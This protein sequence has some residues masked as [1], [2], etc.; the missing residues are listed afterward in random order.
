MVLEKG[1]I[2]PNATFQEVNPRIDVDFHNLKV[3]EIQTMQIRFKTWPANIEMLQFPTECTFWPCK[4]LRRASVASFGFG[5]SNSHVV[6]DDAY[7]YMAYRGIN[8]THY[9]T[10]NQS[11]AANGFKV[12]QSSNGLSYST[13][14]GCMLINGDHQSVHDLRNNGLSVAEDHEAQAESSKLLVLSAADE[15]GVARLAQK[16]ED[17]FRNHQDILKKEP[18][19]LRHLAY[20]LFARKSTFPWKSFVVVNSIE[21]LGSFSASVSKPLNVDTNAQ[22]VFVFTGQGAQ[23]DNMGAELFAYPVFRRIIERFDE[24]LG[25]L[26]CSWSVSCLLQQSDQALDIND[27]EYSQAAATALQ[28]GAYEIL[29]ELGV[30]VAL[31][32]GHSSGEIAAAYA[33]GA[34]SLE[35][36]CRVSYWRGKHASELKLSMASKPG[37]MMSVDLS[38]SQAQAILASFS[39][40]YPQED[41]PSIACINSPLNVT[42]SGEEAAIDLVQD[43]LASQKV[44]FRK[45][46]TGV[47]YHSPHMQAMA[48]AYAEKLNVLEPASRCTKDALQEHKRPIMISSV[49]GQRVHDITTLCTNDYWVQ[50]LVSQVRFSTAM[51]VVSAAIGRKRRRKLGEPKLNVQDIIE[52]G[53]HSALR[54]PV[55]ACLETSGVKNSRD[56]YHSI[57]SRG[58]PAAQSLL[59]LVGRLYSRGYPVR[60]CEANEMRKTH[61]NT[62]LRLI[63]DL[64]SYPFNHTKS[65]WSESTISKNTR[66]RNGAALHEL[67]GIPVPDW[68]AREPRWRKFFDLNETPWI[69]HH[70]VNGRI[71]YPAAGMIAMAIEGAK[72][73]TTED[74]DRQIVAYQIRDA[75]FVA[76]I[77][78]NKSERTE[79]QLHMRLNSAQSDQSLT[80]FEF[81]I[82]SIG[83]N[84]WFQNCNGIVQV[85][86][87]KVDSLN[88]GQA[89][90]AALQRESNFY[91]QKYKECAKRSIHSVP[92]RKMY[93]KLWSNGLQFGPA[94]Q[95]LN[96]MAWDGENTAVGV[97]KCFQ[98]E[99]GSELSYNGRQEHVV[100]PTSLDGAGHLPWVALTKGGEEKIVSGT[101]VT[102]IQYAWI[103]GNGLSYPSTSQIRAC[104]ETS[105]KG[106]RGTDSSIFAL[107]DAGNLVLRISNLETTALGGDEQ[108]SLV[109]HPQR[110]CYEMSYQPELDCLD[111]KQLR[112]FIDAGTERV[113]DKHISFYEDLELVLFYFATTALRDGWSTEGTKGR[114]H[115][116]KYVS[117]LN[118][119][120]QRY[121][122]CELPHGRPEWALRSQ[123]SAAMEDLINRLANTNAEGRF[124]ASVGRKL[125]SILDGTTDPLELMFQTDLAEK[126]YQSICDHMMW[127]K[128]MKN[129]LSAFS[130]KN[131][132]L[133]VIEVGAGTGSITHHVLEGLGDKFSHYDYTDISVS[134]FEQAQRSFSDHS[135][136]MQYSVLDIERRPSEQG[137]AAH[138]YDIVV[139]AWVLHA[140]QDLAK[141]IS[142]V[143]ELLKPGGKLILGEITQPELLRNGFAFGTLPG[144]WLG[145]EPEREW[146]PCLSETQW[147][148]FLAVNGFSGV[149][150]GLSDFDDDTCHEHSI[151]ISTAVED[152]H[153]N[154]NGRARDEITL[155]T[156][157]LSSLQS[158][159]AREMQA[160][161][162][163]QDYGIC[164]LASIDDP[165][166]TRKTHT[167]LVF[168][169]ELDAPYLS[170]LDA[171][172]FES[173]QRLLCQARRSLWVTSA[174][175]SSSSSAEQCM[176]RGLARVLF[177]E[178]PGL[179]LATLA[180]ESECLEVEAY[181]RLAS[182]L[183]CKVFPSK[184][185][186]IDEL[187]Y[188]ERDG[189]LHN[190]RVFDAQ[191]LNQEVH[192]K[193]TILTRSQTFEQSPPLT[194]SIPKTGLLE[195]ISWEED[196]QHGQE[197]GDDEVEIQIQAIGVNFRDLLVMLGKYSAST[198][199]CECAGIVSR[200]GTNCPFTPGDRVCAFLIG[201]SKTYAR[202]HY[203]LAVKIP[204]YLSTAEAASL[205]CTGVTAYHSL[206]TLA[207]LTKEDSILI[208]SATGGVGQVAVQIAKAIGAEI[209]VTV[210]NN[211]KRL[212]V[213]EL[214]GLPDDHIF[215]SRDVT[216][217]R[218]IYRVTNGKGVD[219]VLNSLSKESLLASWECVAPFGRFIELG[220]M[221]IES[222]SKL[223]MVQ[224]SKNVA[225][226]AVAVDHLSNYK[227]AIVG[228]ALSS[229]LE[230]MEKELVTVAQPL[231]TYSVSQL[232]DA[233]RFM[234]SGNHTGKMVLTMDP[235]DTVQVSWQFFLLSLARCLVY[236]TTK[237]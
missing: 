56:R 45:L 202:C 57:L 178:K 94:F 231:K 159:V 129:Y 182:L 199:G 196:T 123:D 235:L 205:P 38:E 116:M 226:F 170:S 198:V 92:T 127:R 157:P 3:R 20:T 208:H 74:S 75:S 206:V 19:Y 27:P 73:V 140:T 28:I 39:N 68:N 209:F 15:K 114:P 29:Q 177:T 70:Q 89:M 62:E 31:V 108:V 136:K 49:S 35:A 211:D 52:I 9:T 153:C 117:W 85:L 224:F 188:V 100:H 145:T 90:A 93:D 215:S 58:R 167:I 22:T 60:V 87:E 64:P 155:I 107:D 128:P 184:D 144:W 236:H 147:N 61:K 162:E 132:Q 25:R 82:Y 148:K 171:A 233:L 141:T 18:E 169:V 165:A 40:S 41:V 197:L 221:D 138:S 79:A 55:L 48:K 51:A 200:A 30:Q 216:F 130:H 181:S 152:V 133:K 219:V 174:T 151:L 53:P 214:Y 120:L 168:L 190:I 194:L 175:P 103:A 42:I 5:G 50:N 112:L 8:G 81:S 76:P 135:A 185:C 187:E 4:G 230:L 131:P 77:S 119:Q 126:H 180:F 160:Y 12:Q 192:E 156:S 59:D 137:F 179:V 43:M 163:E 234:Q 146:S 223:P 213:K 44:H 106:T 158:T 101:A 96:H 227:P 186:S 104:C 23:Y 95:S 71:I 32:V 78:I 36:A 69:G 139:A 16:Y 80:S 118:R 201:C 232:E 225:F 115:I 72:Q 176:I 109:H 212:L 46:N 142:H 14:N 34:L 134:F 229:I 6:L 88:G 10:S 54:R 1:I 217:A 189:M 237:Q 33:A 83:S 26:G 172:T 99:T 17:Y 150:I 220:K 102:R 91:Q 195:S 67:L 98:W 47:A 11:T 111:S 2:P 143:R 183:L 21:C 166:L 63:S 210:G 37:A 204:E 228:N 105:L 113:D 124:F 110:L 173:L 66:L 191:S 218:D 65:Y 222:N 122:S 154:G 24:E 149:D 193:T 97:V 164:S 13:P 161:L 86:F 203:K 84:G 207:Q 125:P 121:H 7:H